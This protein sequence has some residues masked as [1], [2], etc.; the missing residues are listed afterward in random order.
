MTIECVLEDVS[1]KAAC[2]FQDSLCFCSAMLSWGYHLSWD[3]LSEWTE[4]PWNHKSR[5]TFP[6]LNCFCLV[7]GHHDTRITNTAPSVL[8]PT[9][10][11]LPR[12]LS[13][14][15]QLLFGE[16]VWTKGLQASRDDGWPCRGIC[17]MTEHPFS[18]RYAILRIDFRRGGTEPGQLC[19]AVLQPSN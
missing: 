16:S 17:I 5:Y 13:N 1:H 12:G 10:V 11:P 14:S 8:T 3:L 7:F 15:P 2:A 18:L 6:L 19:G 4:N 9:T